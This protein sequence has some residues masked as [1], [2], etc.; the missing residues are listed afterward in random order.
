MSTTVSSSCC[1]YEWRHWFEKKTSGWETLDHWQSG[2][3]CILAIENY[4][5]LNW[6]AT[7]KNTKFWPKITCI[8]GTK[9][10]NSWCFEIMPHMH[11]LTKLEKVE[12]LWLPIASE[13]ASSCMDQDSVV[14]GQF[15]DASYH[16]ARPSPRS[17]LSTPVSHS[18][19]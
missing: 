14:F 18:S 2:P 9:K 1:Q 6:F 12:I 16:P 15:A 7:E 8:F 5:S 10:D 13:V 4:L 17:Y 19:S 3:T 11:S